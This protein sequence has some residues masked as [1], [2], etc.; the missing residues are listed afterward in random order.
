[1]RFKSQALLDVSALLSCMAYVDLNPV[2]AGVS[3]SLN[4]SDFTS[5]KERIKQHN[6]YQHNIDKSIPDISVPEQPPS[7]LP[8]AGV[9]NTNAIPFSLSDYLA[10][11]DWS[12]R[13]ID[14][15]KS[16]YLEATEPKILEDLGIDQ[17]TWLE[18]VINF[19]RQYGS[20]AGSEKILRSNAHLHG[21]SW[22]KGVH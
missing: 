17:D 6:A 10:L 1:M 15:H 7:L 9:D 19:R 11:T 4:T 3:H 18:A 22:H 16:G 12:G 13:H 8:F 20:F 21:C 2:R 5:I 14:P